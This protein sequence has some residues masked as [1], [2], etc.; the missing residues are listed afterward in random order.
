MPYA[1]RKKLIPRELDRRVK[2]TDIMRAKIK[3]MYEEGESMRGI[4]RELDISR[5]SIQFILFPERL[6]RH[7]KYFKER[8]QHKLTYERYKREGL[9]PEIMR[10]HTHYKESIKKK[11]LD[12]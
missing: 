1:H 11:L 7:K 8:Q 6:L 3:Q 5:R 2:I 4:A 12:K 9:W 10:E